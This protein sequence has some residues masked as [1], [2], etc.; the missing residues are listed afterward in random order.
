MIRRSIEIPIRWLALTGI[1]VGGAVFA[2]SARAEGPVD[3]RIDCSRRMG[4]VRAL[5][6]VNNGP[7]NYGETIDLSAYY[8]RA[9]FPLVRL[10]DS[11]WPNPD[12]VDMH[13]VFPDL[14]ADPNRPESYRFGRTDDYVKA[15]VD[16]GGGIVYRLGESIETT[17]RKVHVN[18]PADC[19]RW[20]EACVGIIRHYNEGWAEGFRYKIRYWEIWNEPENRPNMWTGTDEDYYR[21]YATAARRIKGRFP[22]LM[23]GGPSTGSIGEVKDGR[24]LPT[25]FLKGFIGHCK[26][27]RAPLDFFSWHTYSDDPYVF[28]LK[29]RAVRRYLDEQGYR[30]TEN[31]LNEW[32][33]LPDN[34]WRPIS[35]AGQGITR[36]RWYARQGGAE[37]AAF[38]ACGLMHLQDSPVDVANYYRG[39]ANPFGL[40]NWHG[41]PKKTYHAMRAFRMLLETP[42]RVKAS[43]GQ[44]GHLAVCAGV[45]KDRTALTVLIGNFRH[46]ARTLDLRIA[47]VPW[48]GTARWELRRL[49]S[50]KDLEPV[51]SGAMPGRQL[52]LDAK[53]PAPCVIVI[54]VNK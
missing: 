33:Y 11:E 17:R 42:L 53:C 30:K 44:P 23:V 29:A 40:F 52:R 46:Q 6:G 7:V 47:P 21:L 48:Q 15:I 9:A 34:D 35:V 13:A 8:R 38:L 37:G 32:N 54:K 3:V 26:K 16:S 25:S 18:P 45:N 49:D 36:Q 27:H 1:A 14:R 51:R 39:D 24:L 28:A 43:G 20:A 10:H 5:H 31:H 41:V 22:S 2:G 12:V 4:E 50:G 19:R